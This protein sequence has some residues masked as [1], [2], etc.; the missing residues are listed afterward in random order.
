MMMEYGEEE[1]EQAIEEALDIFNLRGH[2]DDYT[3]KL[4]QDLKTYLSIACI[5]PLKPKVYI[6]DEPTT[7]LDTHGIEV[8]MGA[9]R[10]LRDAGHTIAIVTHDMETVARYCDRAAV[11]LDGQVLMAGTT[12]EVFAQPERLIEADIKPP[13]ITQLGHMLSD[14][15]MPRD[16][17]TVPEMANILLPNLG[18]GSPVRRGE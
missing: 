8:M 13:Q 18:V 7:G 1:T 9:L 14:T 10:V 4:P 2:G 3:M 11:M 5:Y 16:I 6:I 17:L 15:G 12:R